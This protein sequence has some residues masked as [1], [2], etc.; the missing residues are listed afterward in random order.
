MV[1]R[2]L[3]V[4]DEDL[5][6]NIILDSLSDQGYELDGVGNVFD[7]MEL[8][9]DNEYDVAILD[10]NMPGVENNAEGGLEV[11]RFL[12]QQTPSTEAIMLTGYASIETALEAMKLGAFDYISKPFEV[13]DLISKVGKL[14]KRKELL[15]AE[16][17][18][19]LY[20]DLHDEVLVYFNSKTLSQKDQVEA[21]NSMK[22]KVS[23]VFD[24]CRQRDRVIYNQMQELADIA[25]YSDQLRKNL[26]LTSPEHALAEKIYQ[27]ATGGNLKC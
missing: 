4:D 26:K 20:K 1:K 3:V 12:K 13:D 25:G 9:R 16:D 10:K 22:R 11:L 6:R 24:A 8:I 7:A 5:V 19:P 14:A 23:S 27:K 18:I 2:V 21:L 15:D 17:I